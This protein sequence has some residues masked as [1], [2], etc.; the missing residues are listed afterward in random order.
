MALHTMLKKN[1]NNPDEADVHG[2]IKKGRSPSILSTSPA[3][4]S[5]LGRSG[6]M[7]SSITRARRAVSCPT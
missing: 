7:T 1:L 5:M 4:P 3:L 6:P 2:N